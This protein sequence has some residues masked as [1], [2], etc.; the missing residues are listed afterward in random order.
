MEQKADRFHLSAPIKNIDLEQRSG[1]TINDVK[2]Y[3]NHI[4][5]TK[6]MITYFKDKNLK[7]KKKHKN[8]KTLNTILESVETNVI[9]GAMSTSL[10]PSVT[11]IGLINLIAGI[12]CTLSLGNKIL[13]KMITNKSN[14]YKK[15]HE[16]VQQTNKSFDK[17][18]RK[19]LQDKI[20]DRSLYESLC[21][22]FTK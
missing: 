18:Y 16:N 20:I 7:S 3:K 4:N 21:N 22:I 1:K 15:Q 12:A 5:N 14:K 13:L 11:G 9:I 6:E 17:I 19:T 10:N 8:S 2:K